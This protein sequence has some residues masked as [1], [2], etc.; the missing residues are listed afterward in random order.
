MFGDK[1]IPYACLYVDMPW[2]ELWST[3][4]R[5]TLVRHDPKKLEQELIRLWS[6]PPQN[7]STYSSPPP[8]D[9]V[10]GLSARSV[11]DAYLAVKRYPEGSFVVMTAINIPDISVVVRAH[12]LIP[13]PID[14]KTDTLSPK[15]EQLPDLIKGKKCVAFLAAHLYG[16]RMDMDAV[17]E[18]CQQH[19][20]DVIEDCA[21]AFVGLSYRGHPKSDLSFFSFGSIKVCTAFGGSLAR[22]KDPQVRSEMVVLLHSY[23]RR[24]RRIYLSK[25]LRNTAMMHALN[26]PILTGSITYIAR[27][28]FHGD[29]KPY[30]VQML[31]GFPGNLLSNIRQQPSEC[32]LFVLLS[33]LSSFDENTHRQYMK[34]CDLVAEALH[35]MCPVPGMKA[36]HRSHWL[37]PILV[38]D[39][40]LVIQELNAIG[41]DAYQ[42]ATQL[43]LVEGGSAP[44]A[45]SIMKRVIYL[46]VHKA[47]PKFEMRNIVKRVIA[48]VQKRLP[49]KL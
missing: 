37:F 14:V 13:L 33:R 27:S 36:P 7:S 47:V 11:L 19:G 32:L 45:A 1:Q 48:V 43:A 18:S 40:D 42:G 8:L 29:V 16:R 15:L 25:A 6:S 5:S 39:R 44:E 10:V 4:Y 35:P 31:R 20:L 38:E 34:K 24:T 3:V 26:V 23:P 41:V 9:A 2:K 30:A 22:V 46:P 49:S 17:V 28:V 12:G 21:E